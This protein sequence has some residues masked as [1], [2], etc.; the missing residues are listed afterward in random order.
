[1]L[2]KRKC[3]I[4]EK[5]QGEGERVDDMKFPGI[6][7]ISESEQPFAFFNAVCGKWCKLDFALY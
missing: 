5:K 1:M 6:Y 7:S 3:G 4:P 2:I